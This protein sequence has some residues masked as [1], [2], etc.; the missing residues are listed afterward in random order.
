MS[1]HK[2]NPEHLALTRREFLSR[3][4]MGM[5]ALSLGALLQNSLSPAAQAAGS[6]VNPL[7]ARSGQFPGTA[8]VRVRERFDPDMSKHRLYAVYFDIYTSLYNDLRENFYR[9]NAAP[10]R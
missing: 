10:G 8:F 3:C 6:Y 7:A 5:G 9:L 4:G 1:H 2:F